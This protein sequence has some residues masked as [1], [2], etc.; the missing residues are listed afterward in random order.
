MS[1][2]E[3]R[4]AQRNAYCRSCDKEI[5]KKEEM[6]TLWSRRNRGQYIHLCL[7]CAK[8]IG[9]LAEGTTDGN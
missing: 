8:K 3:R 7:E 9:K 4:E 1:A 2:P 6:I 5:Q